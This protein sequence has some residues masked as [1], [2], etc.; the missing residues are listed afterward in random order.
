LTNFFDMSKKLDLPG[1]PV[2]RKLHLQK[3]N[4]LL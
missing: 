2:N 1:Q 3:G 4:R